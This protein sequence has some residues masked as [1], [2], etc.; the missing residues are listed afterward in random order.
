M[1]PSIGKLTKS[2]ETSV[3]RPKETT[4]S[5]PANLIVS[6]TTT[7]WTSP[8]PYLISKLVWVVF[9]VVESLG[10]KVV[11]SLHA[12]DRHLLE[13]IHVSEL[14]VSMTRIN[15]LPVD[16]NWTSEKYAVVVLQSL[17]LDLLLHEIEKKTHTH[18]SRP[19]RC[20]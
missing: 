6:E 13:G 20:P 9:S 7:P 8:L 11:W 15:V 19:D 3:A 14:P 4:S 17:I 16:P 10:A 1:I 18:L 5:N 12:V 2:S